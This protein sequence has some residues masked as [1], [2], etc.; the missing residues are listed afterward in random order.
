ME[1]PSEVT[2]TQTPLAP[3]TAEVAETAEPT[4]PEAAPEPAPE[5][6]EAPGP[7][8]TKEEPPKEAPYATVKG[9]ELAD[10]YALLDHPEVK[11]HFERQLRRDRETLQQQ[12]DTATKETK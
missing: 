11:P 2:A 4:T 7:S 5:E 12:Y 3:E 9:E 10:E 6:P 8:P 1:D